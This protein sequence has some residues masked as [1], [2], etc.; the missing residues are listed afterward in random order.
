[1]HGS[2]PLIKLMD[3]RSPKAQDR[4]RRK[5]AEGASSN[6]C[7]LSSEMCFRTFR[8]KKKL[9]WQW[10]PMSCMRRFQ[11]KAMSIYQNMQM[12]SQSGLLPGT[13]DSGISIGWV[14]TTGVNVL[15]NPKRFILVLGHLRTL[16][17]RLNRLG[18]EGWCECTDQAQRFNL[19]RQPAH[20]VHVDVYICRSSKFIVGVN[21]APFLVNVASLLASTPRSVHVRSTFGPRCAEIWE[22]SSRSK[23]GPR[24]AKTCKSVQV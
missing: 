21:V 10:S 23:F 15:T 2:T 11:W 8:R 3:W 4:R 19:V 13:S 16:F 5:T 18:T 1:M 9:R 14:Q 6:C 24:C 22:I 12:L 17:M 20:T 7:C